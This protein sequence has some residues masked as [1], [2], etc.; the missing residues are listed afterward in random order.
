M[1][2]NKTYIK[3]LENLEDLDSKSNYLEH[4]Q[5]NSNFN[6]FMNPSNN[7]TNL[8]IQ[9]QEEKSDYNNHN[10]YGEDIYKN[11]STPSCLDIHSHITNCPICS[12]FFKND[13]SVYIISIIILSVICILLLKKVLNL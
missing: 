3:D 13:N 11:L 6:N 2:Y 12:K 8:S 4:N 5:H 7:F 9:N 10:L 1:I